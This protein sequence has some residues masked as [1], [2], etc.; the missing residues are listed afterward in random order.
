MVINRAFASMVISF[1]KCF[2]VRVYGIVLLF[3]IYYINH[4]V[5]VIVNGKRSVNNEQLENKTPAEIPSTIL[6][7]L[8]IL[9]GLSAV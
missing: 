1:P 7:E 5:V 3:F 2:T 4:C 8:T 9:R 6:R